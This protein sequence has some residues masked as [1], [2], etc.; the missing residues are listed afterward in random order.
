M[1]VSWKNTEVLHQDI[2]QRS[3]FDLLIWVVPFL[4][5]LNLPVPEV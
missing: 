4:L 1:T 5:E 2:T 3:A